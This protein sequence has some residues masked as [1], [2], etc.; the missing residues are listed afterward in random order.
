MTIPSARSPFAAKSIVLP[1]LVMIL[2]SASFAQ[3][4]PVSY[5]TIPASVPLTT[6]KTTTTTTPIAVAGTTLPGYGL[7]NVAWSPATAYS[8]QIE[9][10]SP[11][12]VA[13]PFAWGATADVLNMFANNGAEKY[14]VTFT[15][16]NG[17]PDPRKLLLVV[18]GLA[19]GTTA[20]VIQGAVASNTAVSGLL[21][22]YQF[23][24]AAYKTACGCNGS[25]PTV[26]TGNVLS[27]GWTSTSGLD[28]VNT[29]WALFQATSPIAIDTGTRLPTLSVTVNQQLGDGIGLTLGYATVPD[30]CCPPFDKTIMLEQLMLTQ[31]PNVL[32]DITYS[33][34]NST[35]NTAAT[36]AAAMQAYINYLNSLNSS[37]NN[38]IVEWGVFDQGPSGPGTSPSSTLGPQIGSE[39]FTEWSCTGCFSSSGN[40]QKGVDGN[41]TC[42]SGNAPVP[43]TTIPLPPNRWYAISTFAYLNNGIAFW[44]ATCSSITATFD[45]Y[46]DPDALLRRRNPGRIAVEV[47]ELGA[48]SGRVVTLPLILPGQEERN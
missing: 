22:E 47:R 25:S 21:Y 32:G 26:L 15:F 29:G 5:M 33:F 7:V 42:C 11:N 27:S 39:V 17:P 19:S 16:L 2:A 18:A 36:P 10:F 14:T 3:S 9:P 38:I 35:P 20:T 6:T 28:Q 41:L 13:G 40:G 1:G 12:G 48:T 34:L 37:I 45:V 31:T 8:H 30:A 4:W 44:S 43:I 24:Y 46:A 23:T